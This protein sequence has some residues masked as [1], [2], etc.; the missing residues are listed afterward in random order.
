ME[1]CK[2]CGLVVVMMSQKG[3]GYCSAICEESEEAGFQVPNPGL[4]REY[5][6]VSLGLRGESVG[7]NINLLPPMWDKKG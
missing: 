6:H 1:R 7:A 2:W 5:Q 3:R 4:V